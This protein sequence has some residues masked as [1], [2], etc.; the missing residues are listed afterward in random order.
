MEQSNSAPNPGFIPIAYTPPDG[1]WSEWP[2]AFLAS[3]AAERP[4]GAPDLDGYWQTIEVLVDGAAVPNHPGLGH[5]QRVEQKGDRVIVTAAGIVHDM[6][7]DGTLE[8]GVHDVAESDKTT[9][10]NMIAS[11]EDGV[12]V[13]RPQGLDLGPRADAGAGTVVGTVV[14]TVADP[15]GN[16]VVIEIK[17]WRE[18]EHMMW[19]YFGFTARLARL[20]P[21][22]TDPAEVFGP[23]KVL[24]PAEATN[25]H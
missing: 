19:E 10:I 24:D 11:Y 16:T 7:C 25:K 13:L 23:T 9:E 14:G 5:V 6:R 3:C 18:G 12:H 22:D 2:A 4:A 21:A 15:V 8:N 1:G 20:A 17:R